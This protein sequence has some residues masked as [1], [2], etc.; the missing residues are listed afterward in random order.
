MANKMLSQVFDEKEAASVLGVA[1]QT[2]RNWRHKRK[3]PAYLKIG[4]AVRYRMADLEAYL[5]ECRI[6]P[7]DSA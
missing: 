7:V 4:K 6:D 1:V 5:Q 2:L 3:G